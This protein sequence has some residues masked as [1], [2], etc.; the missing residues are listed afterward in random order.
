MTPAQWIG[1]GFWGLAFAAGAYC[2]TS[3]VRTLRLAKQT[4]SRYDEGVGWFHDKMVKDAMRDFDREA[5][6]L[7]YRD[8]S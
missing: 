5:A 2:V 7:L 1:I 8:Q 6:R 3:V 4:K